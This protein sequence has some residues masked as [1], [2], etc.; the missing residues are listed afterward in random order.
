MSSVIEL[1]QSVAA[2]CSVCCTDP[3][4]CDDDHEGWVLFTSSL[5]SSSAA[6]MHANLMHLISYENWK[7]LLAIFDRHSLLLTSESSLSTFFKSKSIFLNTVDRLFLMRQEELRSFIDRAYASQEPISSTPYD[8]DDD[9]WAERSF[10]RLIQAVS[11]NDN[12]FY[13]R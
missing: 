11:S 7:R 1:F 5:L 12:P 13:Q 8:I 9:A 6:D 2:S 10:V 4:D 3:K